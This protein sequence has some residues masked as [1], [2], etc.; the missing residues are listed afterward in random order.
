MAELQDRVS[1]K[2]GR[3]LLKLDDGREIYATVE[4][5]D[6]PT[7]PGNKV[8]RQNVID[9]LLPESTNGG[10]GT[11]VWTAAQNVDDRWLVCDGSE[12]KQD[13]HPALWN[14]LEEIPVQSKSVRF[15]DAPSMYS[16]KKM[17]FVNGYYILMGCT[18]SKTAGFAFSRTLE[19]PWQTVAGT[20]AGSTA[21]C[22]DMVYAKG[23]WVQ[24]ENGYIRYATA[25][26]G[27]WSTPVAVGGSQLV[28]YNNCLYAIN[29]N[30]VYKATSPTGEWTRI[31]QWSEIFEGSTPD[32]GRI[33]RYSNAHKRWERI[34]YYF[35]ANDSGTYDGVFQI[36]YSTDLENWTLGVNYTWEANLSSVQSLSAGAYLSGDGAYWV[37]SEY[38]SG[39]N[40]V[41]AKSGTVE[42]YGDGSA[43]KI[44]DRRFEQGGSNGS[45]EWVNNPDGANSLLV[46]NQ[47]GDDFVACGANVRNYYI[48]EE[49]PV[50]GQVVFVYSDICVFDDAYLKYRPEITVPDAIGVTRAYIKAK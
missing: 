50:N 24:L 22:T 34:F 7:V 38:I 32:L 47:A 46:R 5:A 13:E 9:T 27:E 20:Y 33:V 10:V 16:K 1:A 2:P 39:A 15:L 49:Q 21:G 23:Y 37:V 6:E 11:V 18:A 4:M 48:A 41:R 36:V 12:V 45:S 17:A 31:V 44:A 40:S 26:D 28:Y 30:Y 19:G 8:N 42:L 25:L 43:V 3:R 29:A 35:F 14:V